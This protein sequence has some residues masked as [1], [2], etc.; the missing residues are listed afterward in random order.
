MKPELE[1]LKSYS[2]IYLAT[3][4]TKYPGGLIQ[5]FRAASF[6]AARLLV[7]GLKVYS[8]IAHT[9]PI[10]IYGNI[11]PLDH[12]IWLPFDMTMMNVSDA[13]L[14]AKMESWEYSYGISEEMKIFAKAQKPIFY[15]TPETLEIS[16]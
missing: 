7:R 14:I 16:Q 6:I 3:P 15:L 11:N 4:Y 5:A 10:A 9:H 13:L 2:L 8:P 1:D 12:T